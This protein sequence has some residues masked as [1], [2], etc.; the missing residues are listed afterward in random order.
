MTTQRRRRATRPVRKTVS[1][2]PPKKRR[3]KRSLSFK[4]GFVQFLIVLFA[5][6]IAALIISA[7]LSIRRCSAPVVEN[8]V[9]EV[10][11]EPRVLQIEVLN[12]CGVSGVADKYTEF[13]RSRGFDIVRSDNYESFNVLRTVVIDRRGNIQNAIQIAQTLGLT[14]N[15]VLQEVNE[16]YL[17]D[18]SII[19]GKD[20]RQLS[21]WKETG[22]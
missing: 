1:A 19:I 20:F 12:G 22:N 13:L 2:R 3:K 15:R 14:E 21:S 5:L 16:A 17:I 4:E 18:A 11:E 6:A 7:V 9:E 8:L 10:P